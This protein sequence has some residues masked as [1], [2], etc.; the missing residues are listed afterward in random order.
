[1]DTGF[2]RFRNHYFAIIWQEGE[3]VDWRLFL[4]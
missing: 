4:N 2:Q 1:M 3:E